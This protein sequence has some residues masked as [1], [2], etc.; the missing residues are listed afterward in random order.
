[1][2]RYSNKKRCLLNYFFIIIFISLVNAQQYKVTRINNNQPLIAEET[3]KEVGA[4]EDEYYNIN[5]PAI[6]RVPDW[7]EVEDRAALEARYYLY[8]A[9]HKGDYIRMAWSDSI[10]GPWHLYHI[11]EDYDAGQR[12]VLDMGDDDKIDLENNLVIKRHIASPD[13]HVDNENQRIVMYFHGPAYHGNEDIGQRTFVATS[14]FGLDFNN[15]IRSVMLGHSY[16]RVFSYDE[17]LY[18]LSNDGRPYKAPDFEEPWRIP[19]GFDFSQSLWEKHP[20]NP[21]QDDIQEEGID[22]SELRVRHPSVYLS[23][24]ILQVF[25]SRRGDSPERIQMST[26][27][28]NVGDWTEWDATYPPTEIMEAAPGWEGG[29]LPVYPSKAGPAPEDV[30]QLRDSYVFEDKDGSLYLF[31]CGR[32]EDAIGIARLEEEQT[33]IKEIANIPIAPRLQQN[34]PNPFN[35]STRIEF[36]LH[37]SGK[38]QLN[39]YD[40]TGKYVA[41]LIDRLLSPG[42]HSVAWRPDGIASGI[43]YYQI[44]AGN[45]IMTR[46]MAYLK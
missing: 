23:D 45:Y 7:T 5:G 38:V 11:G 16:F 9:H 12:G 6:I 30:N 26:I 22:K 46:R 14:S 8:F 3:F 34:Y 25:Y 10:T 2:V 31:Y 36:E 20:D 1:M 17:G 13:V 32:G 40:V 19:D 24:G 28:L 37:K 39:I 42:Q 18:A 15:G 44:K 27:D 35:S 21:F 41:S 29:T 4:G 33:D 43:Y